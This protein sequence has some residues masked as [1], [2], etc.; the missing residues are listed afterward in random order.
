VPC[1]RSAGPRLQLRLMMRGCSPLGGFDGAFGAW[2]SGPRFGVDHTAGDCTTLP[3]DSDATEFWAVRFAYLQQAGAL[4]LTVFPAPPWP[5]PWGTLRVS[6]LDDR[7]L[8]LVATVDD[9]SSWRS[10]A[11]GTMRFEVGGSG[12]VGS[13]QIGNGRA[14][15]DWTAPAPLLGGQVVS[16]LAQPVAGGIPAA[17]GLREIFRPIDV[18]PCVAHPVR[19]RH[20]GGDPAP[21]RVRGRRGGRRR[22][23]GPPVAGSSGRRSPGGLGDARRG[24]ADRCRSPAAG[25]AGGW[26]RSSLRRAG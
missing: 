18:S 2:G 8:R 1:R 23:C 17:P 15:L 20:P 19:R 5:A 13:A 3:V 11:A 14:Q 4:D 22:R 6:Q 21:R 25:R 9:T 12:R 7:R 26:D 16:V 10:P 24:P